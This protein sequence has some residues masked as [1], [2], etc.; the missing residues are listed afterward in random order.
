MREFHHLRINH[1]ELFTD[2]GNHI[3]GIEIFWNRAKRHLRKFNGIHRDRF[4]W[5]LKE[6]QWRFNGDNRQSLYKQLKQ[7]DLKEN[8]SLC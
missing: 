2:R 6:C 1:S 3:N 8:I 7:W 4:H 5:F